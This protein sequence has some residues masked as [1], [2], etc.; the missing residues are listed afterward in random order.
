MRHIDSRNMRQSNLEQSEDRSNSARWEMPGSEVLPGL[1]LT[2]EP[3]HPSL[4]R[5]QLQVQMWWEG[6]S[7]EGIPLRFCISEGSHDHQCG[8]TYTHIP[9]CV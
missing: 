6:G 9:S 8:P 3:S 7:A 1:E 5:S 4:S 2:D